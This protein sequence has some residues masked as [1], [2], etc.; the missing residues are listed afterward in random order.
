[1]NIKGELKI[2]SKE[3]LIVLIAS[4]I[5]ML[6]MWIAYLLPVEPMVKNMVDSYEFLSGQYE[7]DDSYLTS[8]EWAELLDT[9]TNVI[10]LHEVIYPNT[11]NAFEDSLLAPG[12]NPWADELGDPADGLIKLATER[13]YTDGNMIT[14]ARYWHGYLVFLKPLFMFLNLEGIYILNA[15]VL[16]AL[17]AAVL[18]FFYKRLGMYSIAYLI[19][20]LSMHPEN[21]VQ[22]FQLSAIFYAL[23]ITLLLLLMKK[24]RKDEEILY[25]FVFNGILVAF[26][27][28]LTYPLVTLIIPVL[29]SYLLNKKT[30]WKEILSTII[31]QGISFLIGYAGMWAMKW[32]YATLFTSQ[33]VIKDAIFSVLNRTGVSEIDPNSEALNQGFVAVLQR[34]IGT[35]L[36]DGNM[37]VLMISIIAALVIIVLKRKSLSF[38]KYLAGFTAIMIV[39]PFAWFAV[40]HNHCYFH[41][42]LEW[43]TLCII[44][45]SL[46]VLIISFIQ[47]KRQEDSL[48]K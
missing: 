38:D 27:D 8:L 44:V 34:N 1:M 2:L 15:I 23:N 18:Y 30:C 12:G 39:S 7:R 14:Y 10:M 31:K 6:L 13:S 17:V 45:F 22:S 11:G 16:V 37:L 48:E 40:L 42:H 41:P 32:I 47:G 21:I 36:D 43:R 3:I 28:F 29:V 26:F 46:A 24:E 25:I 4:L 9:D 19:T 35:F 20:V 33:N 5:G